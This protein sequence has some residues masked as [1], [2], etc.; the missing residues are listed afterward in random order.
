LNEIR[1]HFPCGW[2]F[3]EKSLVEVFDNVLDVINHNFKNPKVWEF[4]DLSYIA[5]KGFLLQAKGKS[6]L[7]WEQEKRFTV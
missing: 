6:I 5:G 2:L 4:G 7:L 1:E 3:V